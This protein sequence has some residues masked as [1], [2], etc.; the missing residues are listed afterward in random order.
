MD[1]R[2]V[3]DE[4]LEDLKAGKRKIV[5]CVFFTLPRITD[6]CLLHFCVLMYCHLSDPPTRRMSVRR[7]LNPIISMTPVLILH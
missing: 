7:Y 1:M 3:S 4:K 5:S 6:I 2:C